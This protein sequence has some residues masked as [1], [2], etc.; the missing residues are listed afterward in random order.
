MKRFVLRAAQAE[1]IP[2][3]GAIE[4]AADE[5]YREVGYASFL[6]GDTIPEGVAKRAVDEGRITVAEVDG[7]VVGWLYVTRMGQELC[8]GQVSVLPSHGRLGIGTALLRDL[9]E[10]A[11][12]A[13]SSS[14]AGPHE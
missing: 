5:R 9:I 10:R 4:R 3:L 7:E 6:D 12:A 2:W 13:G 14:A 11:R 8:L 1:D